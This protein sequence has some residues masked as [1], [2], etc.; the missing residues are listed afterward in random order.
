[1]KPVKHVGGISGQRMEV[2][3]IPRTGAVDRII[4]AALLVSHAEGRKM[5]NIGRPSHTKILGVSIGFVVGHIRNGIAALP[6]VH[7]A[8]VD[9]TG[10]M[11]PAENAGAGGDACAV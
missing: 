10:K 11:A 3:N 9:V 5:W 8:E 1:M 4:A 7:L 6:V 2:G